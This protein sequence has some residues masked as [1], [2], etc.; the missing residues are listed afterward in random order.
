M[1]NYN[2]ENVLEHGDYPHGFVDVYQ[3]TVGSNKLFA[4]INYLVQFDD[5]DRR[6]VVTLLLEGEKNFWSEGRVKDA[7]YDCEERIK[8]VANFK[9][10]NFDN[11]EYMT[12]QTFHFKE[13]SN[14]EFG[15]NG[16]FSFE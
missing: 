9:F 5:Q 16:D 3:T 7:L 10:R 13:I 4:I 12:I 6:A 15:T 2:W 11:L 1:K 14:I 8:S